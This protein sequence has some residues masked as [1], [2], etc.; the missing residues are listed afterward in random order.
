[1]PGAQRNRTIG[2]LIDWINTPYHNQILSGIYDYTEKIGINLICFTAG[3]L[4]SN[5]EWERKRNVIID[6]VSRERVDGLLVASTIANIVGKKA[7]EE[8]LYKYY[9]YPMVCMNEQFFDKPAVLIDNDKGMRE[10]MN[11]MIVDHD[12]RNIAYIAGPTGNRDADKRL[13]VYRTM[14]SLHGLTYQQELV[15][16]G[17]FTM[18]S[19]RE[20]LQEL[21]RRNG[22][23]VDAIVCANDDMALGALEELRSR[24]FVSKLSI[25]ITGFDDTQAGK[26]A[27]LTSVRQPIYEVS[28]QATANLIDIL[29]GMS[30]QDTT[31]LKPEL[32]V[33]ESCGCLGEMVASARFVTKDPVAVVPE[34]GLLAA[35]ETVKLKILSIL[36]SSM[37][38][39]VGHLSQ[40]VG[41]MLDGFCHELYEKK[42]A[43]FLLAW[44]KVIQEVM[45]L[46]DVSLSSL[47]S[48]LSVFRAQVLAFIQKRDDIFAAE[49]LLHEAQ[50]MVAET[51]QKDSLM[52]KMMSDKAMQ[53]TNDI[54][55][56]MTT[57]MD[58]EKK[59][60]LLYRGLPQFGFEFCYLSLFENPDYPLQNSRI[61]L[62]FDQ[63][64][65]HP[66]N[67][68]GYVF[69]T[70]EIIPDQFFDWNKPY[71]III[72][73]LYEGT[74]QLGFIVHN[75]I[76]KDEDICE[77][78]RSRISTSLDVG[79][80]F[81][82][83]QL[84]TQ[85]LDKKVRE[86]TSDLHRA[87]S[88]L[89]L[90]IEER[91]KAEDMLRRSEE[92]F[93]D[94][95]L[96]LPTI[97]L[98]TDINMRF[99]FVNKAGM[100]VFG[101]QE[102]DLK[103]GMTFEQYVFEEERPRLLDYCK[104]VIHGESMTFNE[105][106][107][108]KSDGT[109]ITFLIKA[110]PILNR[111]MV[112]GIRWNAID[113]KPMMSTAFVPEEF[114][115]KEYKLS[116][117]EK[118]VLLLVLQGYRNKEI[119]QSLFIAEGTV[120][121]HITSIFA[122]IG[123]KNRDQFFQKMKDYQ[124]SRFGYQSYIFSLFSQLIRE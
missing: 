26:V 59:M 29:N 30:V 15:V 108:V 49:D 119:A 73:S 96:L 37:P 115:F 11:H 103:T 56:T 12:Y 89:H 33:R 3:R 9:E 38:S 25:P 10:L 65:R 80:L 32:I 4:N 64:K 23:N 39:Q 102:E 14:L 90:E 91:T 42:A 47:T 83:I 5:F 114:F 63:S 94:M 7:V 50:N 75:Y 66:L 34:D 17:D 124:I 36:S 74:D 68:A 123:V 57:L 122:K 79:L 85:D 121:D 6:F 72:Q 2:V 19:G 87:N 24:N 84:Q 106:R 111:G 44:N 109:K 54:S 110:V 97:I 28:R 62:A 31:L 21:Y 67:R 88:L 61:I 35:R 71:R 53:K 40:W 55:A 52:R 45:V 16:F 69:P 95:A 104:R 107:I 58:I 8:A 1:M 120:K 41:V 77:I 78:I 20:A 81:E 48:I 60:D 76:H 43:D 112:S 98:D 105:F 51:V 70:K 116:V 22:L 118:D 18:P 99:T 93:R 92:R 86:R 46:E 13:E 117:R 113:I 100:D 27:R 82:K 101:I